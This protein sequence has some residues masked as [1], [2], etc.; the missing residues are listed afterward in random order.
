MDGENG[1]FDG[2]AGTPVIFI[3]MRKTVDWADEDGARNQIDDRLRPGMDLWNGT[4]N[5]PYQRFR[6]QVSEIADLNHS[7]VE[8]ATRANWDEIPDG[9][10]V[11]P[12]DDDDWFSPNAAQ[13]LGA[14]VVPSVRGYLWSTRWIEVPIS[15]GHRLYLLRRRLFPSSPPKWIC[16]TNNYAMLKGPGAK[17]ILGNHITASHWFKPR[18]RGDGTGE[19]K[20]IEGQLSIANRT[21]A[22]IT[23]LRVHHRRH[24]LRQDELVRKFHR[25]RRLYRE[26]D[27]SGVEW[28]RRYVTMMGDLMDEIELAKGT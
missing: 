10:L 25:Y 12:V 4:F 15:A 5:M 14:E 11:L 16:T 6:R 2:R 17:D 21:L 19:V 8:G 13:V 27:P 1:R 18:V 20:Q 22:S 23:S 26:F 7:M 24:R 28:S 9:A 3:W